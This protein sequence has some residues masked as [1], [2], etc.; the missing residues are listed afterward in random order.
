LSDLD[1]QFD[2]DFIKQVLAYLYKK[3]A[4]KSKKVSM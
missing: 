3:T 2:V 4:T 1:Q